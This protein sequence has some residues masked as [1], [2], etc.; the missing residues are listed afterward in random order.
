MTAAAQ[1]DAPHDVTAVS[2]IPRGNSYS[3]PEFKN[4][5]NEIGAAADA[6][7]SQIV[8]CVAQTYSY[9]DIHVTDV[10]PPAGN[11]GMS[12][13]AGTQD[14]IG[15]SIPGLLGISQLDCAGP[16]D[17]VISF[18]LSEA[19]RQ[20]S[21]TS[22]A[23]VRELCTTIAHEAGH[24]FGL[25]HEFRFI[26]DNSSACSDPMSYDTGTCNPDQRYF[27]NKI[28]AC[29]RF[30]EE[31]C[32]CPNNAANSH[33][34][35]FNVFGPGT[36]TVP[37]PTVA[38]TVPAAANAPISSTIAVSSGSRR[39]VNRVELYLNGW[40]WMTLKGAVFV[41]GGG[42]PDPSPYV[43]TLPARVPD[44]IYDIEVKSYDDVE[45]VGTGTIRATKG[46]PCTSADTCLTGQ[47]CDAGRCLWDSPV[48]QFGEPCTYNEFCMS[49]LCTGTQ[50]AQICTQPCI[51]GVEDS[52]PL[53]TATTCVEN[54]PGA[55]VCFPVED[56]GGCCSVEDDGGR[57]A[58]A[59]FALGLFVLAW[60]GRRRRPSTR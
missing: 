52:C 20:I 25:Q 6:E 55:G 37:P 13:V 14:R 43:F 11:Y 49:N 44:G 48:G 50:D 24:A 41:R 23:Y 21:G 36:P 42:Q 17:N 46:A 18:V 1:Q 8:A 4:F 34:L 3:L 58:V 31:P 57:R 40:K 10:R 54:A 56:S 47:R 45:A 15:L 30:T 19:H 35:L 32:N 27:R 60:I 5:N 26:E 12:I 38:F 7:W 28:A 33:A 53:D 51:P 16:L 29:G 39:G 2:G 22:K 59:P 9:F